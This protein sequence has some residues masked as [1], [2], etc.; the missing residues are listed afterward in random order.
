MTKLWLAV[1]VVVAVAAFALFL[2]RP[3]AHD[4]RIRVGYRPLVLALPLYVALDEGFFASEGLDVEAVKLGSPALIVNGLVAG[5]LDASANVAWLTLLSAESRG[6]G[7]LVHAA[8][9]DC[10]D[11]PI[12]FILV[13]S[14][15]PFTSVS[16][17]SGK[18]VALE[19][20]NAYTRFLLDRLAEKYGVSNWS[21][22][23]METQLQ[24]TAL[25]AG[26]VDAVFALEPT[27]TVGETMG[28]ARVLLS[29]P[30][31]QVMG[32]VA[33]GGPFLLSQKFV[34][35]RPDA[36]YRYSRAIDRAISFIE[37][38]ESRARE[39]LPKY[40]GVADELARKVRLPRYW[41]STGLNAG[42]MQSQAD[43]F[44]SNGLIDQ[45]VNV[46]QL[47]YRA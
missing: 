9:L 37:A 13:R 35:S 30:Q 26:S 6:G 45:P 5:S 21:L 29:G 18:R 15:S 38:N 43:V 33:V 42:L 22:V 31:P 17:L 23:P 20:G 25:Q 10:S 46:S 44:A 27:A 7:M 8:Q 39:T 24:L 3:P 28:V 32:D 4:E 41:N 14:D 36:A 34:A 19:P 11:Q 40:T 47:V 12:S 2:A 16:E 1:V